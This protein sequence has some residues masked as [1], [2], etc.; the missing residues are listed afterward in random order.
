MSGKESG[1]KSRTVSVNEGAKL[2]GLS[3]SAFY[4]WRKRHKIRKIVGRLLR[5]DIER[6]QLGD[7]VWMPGEPE[8][9]NKQSAAWELWYADMQRL[10]KEAADAVIEADDAAGDIP[11]ALLVDL[12]GAKIKR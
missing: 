2:V 7:P 5:A 9:Q 4:H 8:P 10:A 6:A 3:R 12:T 1:P 11:A